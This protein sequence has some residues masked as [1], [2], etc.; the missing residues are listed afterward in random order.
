VCIR[1]PL[2]QAIKDIL[3]YDKTIR[4]LC[5]KKT[6]RKKKDPQT[7]QVI[8]K[9]ADLMSGKIYMQN[10][11]DLGSP[12]VK[13]HIN[14]VSIAN[15]LIDLGAEI[16]VMAKGTMDELQVSNLCNTPLVLQLANRST[17]KLEV[18]LED[19]IVSLDSWEYPIDFMVLQLKSNLGGDPLILGRPWLATVDAF[20]SCILGDMTIAHEDSVKKFN[21]HQ[22]NLI[23]H[24]DFKIHMIMRKWYNLF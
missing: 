6:R 22:L 5:I 9:L 11:V 13:I 4:E 14:N 19:I 1:I 8:G 17:V 24:N 18:V 16:N 23:L 10:Y 12:I 20:I 15:T 7:V 21:I 3:I 2:L